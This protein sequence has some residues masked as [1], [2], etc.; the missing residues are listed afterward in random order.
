MTKG[1]DSAGNHTFGINVEGPVTG[2][3]SGTALA[4]ITVTS[5]DLESGPYR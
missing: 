4:T 5:S 3:F 2:G 1:V